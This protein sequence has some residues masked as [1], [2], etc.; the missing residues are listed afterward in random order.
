M[1][2]I[3]IK[4]GI[5]CSIQAF[6]ETQGE[7]TEKAVNLF[8]KLGYET[9][10]KNPFTHK[11]YSF[12]K[13]SFLGDCTGF[14][15]DK[16]FVE[17]W[18]Y[19]DLLFQISKDEIT[20]QTQLFDTQQVDR[21][22]M[23][24][25]LFFVIKLTEDNYNRTKLSKIT[26]EINRVFPMPAMI[27]FVYGQFITLSI[28]NRRIH[29]KDQQKDVL[30]KVTLIKDINTNKPHR[31]HIEILFDL[32]FNQLLETQGFTNFDQLHNAWQKT[33]DTKEL[34]KRFYRELSDWYFWALE[35]VSF[36]D[37]AEQKKEI[38]NA[39]NLIRL[40]TRIIFIWFIREKSLVPDSLFDP[41]K[42]AGI[43][44][45]FDPEGEKTANY[46][47]A[48]LQNL[49]F[50]TLNQEMTKR[51]F[52][53]DEEFQGK[54]PYYGVKTL[55]RYADCFKIE[56]KE[57]LALFKNIPFLNGGLFDCL[58][59]EDEEGKVF[60]I[61][62]FSRRLQKQAVVPDILF[63]GK[64][65]TEDLSGYFGD[66]KKN[67]EKV[68]GLFNI[69][70]AYKFTIAEN[71][72]IEEEVALDPE[73]LGR[74]FEN[75]LASYNPETQTTARKQTG[76]FYT[77][78][79]IVNYMVDE[80]L[81]AYLKQKL[82]EQTTMQEYDADVGLDI[83]FS[84]TEKEHPFDCKEINVLID[85]IDNCKIIDPACGSGA[86]PMGILH[87]LVYILHK[88]D[89][90]NKLW[91]EKQVE[92]AN[93]I[94]DPTIREKTI[95]DIETAFENN[96]LD[97]GRKL[98]LIENCIYGVDI[99]PIAVQIAKLRFF[100]SLVIDQKKTS[101]SSNN[102]GI[103]SLPNLETKV[104]AANTLVGIG[105]QTLM[106]PE[107]QKLEENLKT[108]RHNYFS[109]K[110]RATK[111]KYQYKDKE[112]RKEI[113]ALLKANK[114][115]Y[116]VAEQLAE[117]NPYDQ[118][119]SADFF[120]PEWMFGVKEGFNIV[121]ANPPYIR[122]EE[123]IYKTALKNECEIFNSVSDLY[124]YFY[125]KGIKLLK[126]RGIL[127]F[128]TSNKF[129]R[130]RYGVF[131]RKYL[132]EKIIIKNIVN[133]GEKHVFEAI[134]NTLI[135]IA[136]KG[137]KE[138]NIFSYSDSIEKS[139]KIKFA[140]NGLQDSEWTI[141]KPEIIHLK[142]KIEKLGIPLN[143]WPIRINR[144]LLTGFNEAYIIDERTK[145]DLLEKEPKIK[146][147][148]KPIVRGR[149]IERYF[150]TW[151]G[152]WII[153]LP[154]HFPLHDDL[155]I[156]KASKEAERSFSKEYPFLYNY[157]QEFKDKLSKRNQS[158]TGIRYEWYA[159]QR[160]A[161]DYFGDFKKEKIIWIELTNKNRFS[162]SEN[163]EYILAGAFL[164]T[165]EFLKYLLAFLNSKVCFFY[166]SLICNSSGMA[167][168][169]WKKFA[170]EKIP[171]PKLDKNEQK[172]F[173]AL[174]DKILA[175]TKNEYYLNNTDKKEK[176]NEYERQIDQ[177]VYKLYGLEPNEI[178]IIEG[179]WE[180]KDSVG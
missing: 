92:K 177:L 107:I 166:F 34:N 98:Y 102:F 28:I 134:T 66:K 157:F 78:R 118:N 145:S 13:D 95:A 16:A 75:L 152:E 156:T 88:I 86:F 9:S 117:F 93:T 31:A 105:S 60:Y 162:Y 46:Y 151:K 150:H 3:E 18:E 126:E 111:L 175:I 81:R 138:N 172:P 106:T 87:K 11:T 69:L 36:P 129:L 103:R 144:G 163:E 165:G 55:Y 37:D 64:E 180:T 147:L 50:G 39:T 142:T 85:A 42:M 23:K 170:L 19:V 159:M 57:A 30:E 176:V 20:S 114:W 44:K 61:D 25:Y 135:F 97:Y 116:R 21:S 100:I 153:Y 178:K 125:E 38:R 4:K 2:D 112:L 76:S 43:L 173:V 174:V 67:K 82:T 47:K 10:R 7:L 121:I 17:E 124:T 40:I 140:Q 104:V 65:R 96:E 33:L 79:E 109:A 123:I 59:I 51:R 132:Q 90:Q 89:P 136:E 130:A 72:P 15:E 94:D 41:D 146:N 141:E 154:W 35:T 164:M 110:T 169:Q 1:T 8:A 122:Q 119:A 22:N 77:P 70:S 99:Q 128:I 168:I 27:L 127:S 5:E 58:D 80:S 62:G 48:I 158:E 108:I 143:K 6:L 161:S 148:I 160:Y 120:D 101:D 53:N 74:A 133:F 52:T 155:S 54:N 45:D 83:L 32:S 71:T 73:L 137:Q 63:F 167:T 26:R 113:A 179:K 131:L 29:K 56:Q 24:S 139:D 49:F 14:R 91:K 68:K 149:N 84:Y 115:G 171:I 12:F